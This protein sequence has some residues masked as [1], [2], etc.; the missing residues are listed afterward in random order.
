MARQP[1]SG[2]SG[3][4]TGRE[5]IEEIDRRLGGLLGPLAE[6][7]AKLADAAEKAQAASGAR[8]F[9]LDTGKGPVRLRADYSVRVGSVAER[10]ARAGSAGRDP[11]QPLREPQTA[12]AQPEAAEPALDVFED[13]TGWSLTA[14]MPGASLEA[15]SLAVEGGTLTIA[16]AGS[17]R[18]RA[19]VAV[20]AWVTADALE[21][22]LANGVLELSAARPG[23]A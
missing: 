2:R 14:D 23:G 13:E 11:S 16:T 10:L 15:L 12:P 4:P 3:G 1:D 22:R 18:Y 6:G 17:R 20:P 8:E 7:L 19:E 5:A 21:R 9:T